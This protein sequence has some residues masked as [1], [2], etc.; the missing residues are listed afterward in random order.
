LGLEVW[1]KD[2]RPVVIAAD[3]IWRPRQDSD[4][5]QPSRVKL[6]V[7]TFQVREKRFYLSLEMD[8]PQIIL[9][10][11]ERRN[12]ATANERGLDALVEVLFRTYQRHK[13]DK[14][15]D[16]DPGSRARAGYCSQITQ[17]H[18]NVVLLRAR[19]RELKCPIPGRLS[20]M[21]QAYEAWA[22]GARAAAEDAMTRERDEALELARLS[23]RALPQLP[24]LLITPD[25]VE[26][27]EV[28]VVAGSSNAVAPADTETQGQAGAKRHKKRSFRLKPGSL[29]DRFLQGAKR[30]GEG[31]SRT[32]SDPDGLDRGIPRESTLND[33]SDFTLGSELGQPRD[34]R[35]AIPRGDDN[36]AN[37]EGGSHPSGGDSP[38]VED[39]PLLEGPPLLDK[40]RKKGRGDKPPGPRALMGELP[41]C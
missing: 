18:D 32:L 29:A 38:L 20:E 41:H 8:Q 30:L 33:P 34:T 3:N 10:G 24:R 37:I 2:S 25:P 13:T 11:G 4:R 7:L 15:K 17:M 9:D 35:G 12:V 14:E 26:D 28:E 22:P 40:G 1:S 27:A 21:V 5:N 16:Y 6:E 19:Y 23:S 39:P 36:P 31:L